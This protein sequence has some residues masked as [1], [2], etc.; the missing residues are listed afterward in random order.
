MQNNVDQVRQ[1]TTAAQPIYDKL[2]GGDTNLSDSDIQTMSKA[3]TS[4]ND[5]L[6][7]VQ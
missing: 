5:Y 4:W 7:D 6:R 3:F 2:Q 1:A